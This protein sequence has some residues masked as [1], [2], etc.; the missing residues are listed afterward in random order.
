MGVG[1]GGR[2]PRPLLDFEIFNKKGCFLSFEWK[3]TNFSTFGTPRNI[4]EKDPSG[5]PGKSF[6]R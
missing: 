5:P 2:V 3:K 1:K 4:L 6:R